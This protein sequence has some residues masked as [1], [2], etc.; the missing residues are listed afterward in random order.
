MIFLY[1]IQETDKPVLVARIFN[2]VEIIEDKII[3]PVNYGEVLDDKKARILAKKIK[4][5]LDKSRL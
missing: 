2:I 1:Y 5:I 4:K 3:L